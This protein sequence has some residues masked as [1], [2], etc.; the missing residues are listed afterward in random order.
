MLAKLKQYYSL[1]LY[2]RSS[3]WDLALSGVWLWL[4]TNDWGLLEID[5]MTS[6]SNVIDRGL[7]FDSRLICDWRLFSPCCILICIYANEALSV[8]EMPTVIPTR[9]TS[10]AC[11]PVCAV[12]GGAGCP[13]GAAPQAI[14]NSPILRTKGFSN[15][16]ISKFSVICSQPN[17]TKRKISEALLYL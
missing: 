8:S 1:R 6:H 12:H 3:L 11:P 5:L 14:H 4:W 13:L 7:I 17:I 2:F 15:V 9:R 16:N 10:Y